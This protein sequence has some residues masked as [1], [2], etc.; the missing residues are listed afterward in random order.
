ML[1]FFNS[2]EADAPRYLGDAV[3][4]SP[5]PNQTA[6]LLATQR[7]CSIHYIVIDQNILEEIQHHLGKETP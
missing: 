5:M 7:G 1:Q 2:M 6:Y 4:G 3:Y